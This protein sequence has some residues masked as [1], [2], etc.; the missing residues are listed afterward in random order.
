MG[1]DFSILIDEDDHKKAEDGAKAAFLEAQRLNNV[2][3]DY[4]SESEL[5]LFSQRSGD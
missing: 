3:S 5:S 1:A 2:F 4:E